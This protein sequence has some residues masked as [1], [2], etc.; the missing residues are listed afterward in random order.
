MERLATEDLV[1]EDLVAEDLVAERRLVGHLA[2][3]HRS[4]RPHA[5]GDLLSR[6][7][8]RVLKDVGPHHR[9]SQEAMSGLVGASLHAV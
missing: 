1:A 3:E 9:T 8:G 6:L 7:T 4:D 2:G 5:S